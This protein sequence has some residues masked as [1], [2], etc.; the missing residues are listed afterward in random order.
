MDNL[1]HLFAAYIIIWAGIFGYMLSLDSRQ[2]SLRREIE[3]L[4]MAL[5]ERYSSSREVWQGAPRT[6][7]V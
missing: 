6:T 5:A 7:D 4:K 1:P 3:A 2:R